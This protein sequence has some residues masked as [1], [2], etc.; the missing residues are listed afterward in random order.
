MNFS[1]VCCKQA[2]SAL[3][4]FIIALSHHRPL[5]ENPVVEAIDLLHQAETTQQKEKSKPNGSS[6][7][8]QEPPKSDIVT[9]LTRRFM[10]LVSSSSVLADKAPSREHS[11]YGIAYRRALRSALQTLLGCCRSAK[12]VAVAGDSGM[13]FFEFPCF[14]FMYCTLHICL[15]EAD[16]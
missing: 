16:C 6:S 2:R 11:V 10:V 14:I 4:F 8:A 5:S 15:F 3:N 13:F 7:P 1:H 9:R 12:V